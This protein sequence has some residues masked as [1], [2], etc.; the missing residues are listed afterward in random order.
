MAKSAIARALGCSRQT[1]DR[2]I[3]RY[4]GLGEAGLMDRREDNG[5]RK[6][7][8]FY[9]SILQG[10]LNRGPQDFGYRR[11]TWTHRLLIDV[12]RQ[13]TGIR[14]SRRTMGR[15]LLK[16]LSKPEIVSELPALA[17]HLLE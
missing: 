9:I 5:S 4:R 1:V 3:R 15:L 14:I 17:L 12:A 13:A 16:I 11:P 7:D 6:V 8:T 10:I 2:V